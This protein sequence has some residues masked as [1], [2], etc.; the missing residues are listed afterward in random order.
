[1]I[2]SLP[3]SAVVASY[4]ASGAGIGTAFY[5][6]VATPGGGTAVARA[7]STNNHPTG[8]V[9]WYASFT[10][11][12][13]AGFYSVQWDEGGTAQTVTTI[14][15]LWVSTN[16]PTTLASALPGEL[17]GLTFLIKRNDTLPYLR[18]Q[19]TDSDGVAIDLSTYHSGLGTV[20]FNMRRDTAA[21][22]G[23]TTPKVHAAASVVDASTGIVE[24]RWVAGDTDTT[25]V[26]GALYAGEFEVTFADGKIETFPGTSYIAITI[27]R[28]LDPGVNP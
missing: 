15:D 16:T 4:K 23:A 17:D 8:S 13:T 18:R 6:V 12:G 26:G 14:E 1:M 27:P 10:A 24:Y 25:T 3:G 21:D 11:P 28:D 2:T 9:A 7:A 20:M 22:I 5:R 19:L